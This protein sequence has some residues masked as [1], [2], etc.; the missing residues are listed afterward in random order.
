MPGAVGGDAGELQYAGPLLALVHPTGQ[1]LYVTLGY[2]WS[3]LFPFGSMAWKMNLLAAVS[4]AAGCGALTYLF[5]RIT[6]NHII[7]TAAGLALGFG[8]TIWGQAVIADKYGFNVLLAALL[9]GL[10][11]WWS[12][13]R[14]SAGA[15]SKPT[16]IHNRLLYTLSFT[17]GI[18]LLHHRSLALFALTLGIMVLYYERPQLW[19]NWRRTLICAALVL[20]PPLLVYPLFLP[21]VRA[22]EL[23]PLLWQPNDAADWLNWLLERHVLTGEALVFDNAANISTQLEIYIRT[24]LNDYTF[25]IIPLA[26]IGFVALLRREPLSGLFLL[27]NYG[28]Q[29]FLSANWRGNERQFTYYLPSFVLLVYA[30]SLGLH[31]V[32]LWLRFVMTSRGKRDELA[33]DS[34]PKFFSVSSVSLWLGLF[35]FAIPIAQF[36]ITYPQRHADAIYGEPLDLWRETLKTGDM[37]ARL[38]SGMESLPSGAV[39][40]ADWEQVTILWYYQQVEGV[41]PDLQIFYPIERYSDFPESP[42]CLARHLPVGE[43]WHPTNV[44]ALICLNREPIITIPENITPLGT[45]LYTP[46]NT[47]QLELVGYN[48]DGTV[49]EAGTHIPLLLTWRALADLENDYSISLRILDETQNVLWSRDIAAPVMGMYPTSHWIQGEIVQDY[50]EISIALELPTGRYLWAVVVYRPLEDGTFEQLRDEQGNVNILGGTL[51]VTAVSF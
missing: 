10:T 45:T 32:W 4:A 44:G 49:F 33:H 1:P 24:L 27:V 47:A 48:L 31:A 23:S 50:H 43:E 22:R 36:V 46:D 18:C 17:F 21:L 25:A 14:A 15:G 35:V 5:A 38:A 7:A 12:H 9:I 3:H 11:L 40:A 42:V 6:N 41:R 8:A 51:E 34:P 29:A 13:E 16:L 30:L 20:L 26:L 2:L 39:L 19:R 28:L 37:G